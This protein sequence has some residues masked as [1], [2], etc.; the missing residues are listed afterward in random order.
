MSLS[1]MNP[2][3]FSSPPSSRLPLHPQGGDAVSVLVPVVNSAAPKLRGGSWRLLFL[4]EL[5]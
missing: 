1:Q 3:G 4:W 5:L 2:V